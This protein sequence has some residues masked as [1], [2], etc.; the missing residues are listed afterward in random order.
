MSH[1]FALSVSLLLALAACRSTP[2]TV[3][4]DA[5]QRD[6][7]LGALTALDGHWEGEAGDRD[8]HHDFTVSSGGT[9]VRELMF[10]G[11]EHEMTNMYALDG[12]GI[13]M[14]HYCASGNQPRMRADRLEDNRLVF[15][16]ED[17]TDLASPDDM[18]MGAMTLV[19]L[20]DDRIQEHWTAFRGDEVDHEMVF[21]LTRGR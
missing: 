7:L 2:A 9:V 14:T 6:A 1:R 10:P 5:E 19:F 12:N 18:Y 15:R 3:D 20:D 17:V 13:V 21:E 11:T 16:F 4:G 8:A